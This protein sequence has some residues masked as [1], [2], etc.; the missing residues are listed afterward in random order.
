MKAEPSLGAVAATYLR[1]ANL[2]F[3]GGDPTMAALHRELVVR[4]GW[5]GHAQYGL[6]YGLARVTPGT[7][8]LAFCAGSAWFIRGWP[9][10]AAAVAAATIPSALLIVWLTWAYQRLHENPLARGVLM[11]TLAAAVGMMIAAACQLLR[12]GL[13]RGRTLRTAVLFAAASALLLLRW[14][15]PLQVLG[16]A[17]IA[18]LAWPER[19]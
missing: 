15:G 2:T 17:A 8:L 19:R 1:L 13:E 3:G 5:L 11:G 6:I 18:G 7:N 4:R 12:P 10:A 16:L 9:A 14:L